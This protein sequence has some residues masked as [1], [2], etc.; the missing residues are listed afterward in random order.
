[1]HP[2][3]AP[4][5]PDS[6]KQVCK[7][8]PVCRCEPAWGRPPQGPRTGPG[9]LRQ[10]RSPSPAAAAPSGSASPG[11]TAGLTLHRD[12]EEASPSERPPPPPALLSRGTAGLRVG[13]SLQP[14]GRVR[15]AAGRG[16]HPTRSLRLIQAQRSCGARPTAA[17]ASEDAGNPLP[18]AVSLGLAPGSLSHS[19][20]GVGVLGASSPGDSSWHGPARTRR[21]S[22]SFATKVGCSQHSFFTVDTSLACPHPQPHHH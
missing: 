1:M 12:H 21:P 6:R 8:A 3:A 14:L 15:W 4:W 17:R 13:S 18:G 22:L 19:P 11:S 5:S 20:R 10:H 7:V 16:P 9:G 2:P